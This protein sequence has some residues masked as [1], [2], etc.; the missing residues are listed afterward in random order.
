MRR[1][2]IA[3]ALCIAAPVASSVQGGAQVPSATA[4]GQQP[5]AA[6]LAGA[7]GPR[8]VLDKYCVTCHNQRLKTAGLMLDTLDPARIG[9]RAE[10]WEKVVRKI[11][12]GAMPPA[13]RPRPD[14]ALADGVA[15][16]IEESLDRVAAEH[17]DPGRPTLH[18]LN[19][20][21]YANA[22]RDL[23]ALE[24]D[25]ASLL[26]ADNA[27]YGFDNNADALSLSPALAERY[28]GAAAKIS[29]MAVG[30]VRGSSAAE[31]IF[32]PSDRNQGT[33][34]SEDLPWGSRGGL[35]IRYEFPVEGEYLFQLRLNESG[36][37]GGIMGITAETQTLDVSLDRARIWTTTVG[38]PAAVKEGG[39]E[40]TKK[41][42]DALQFRASVTAGSHLVQAYFTQRT[43]AFLE[44]LFD[45]YL[46]RDPY[47]AGN[48]EPG[49]SSISI[50][51]PAAARKNDS[52]SRRRLFVC[53]PKSAAA[54]DA[55]ARK[56]V[57]RLARRA[58]RRPVTGDDL[59]IPLDRYRD[60]ASGGID[61]GIELAVRSILV[62]PNF[63][64]RFERQPE[65]A[66]PNT[67]YRISDVEL[68]SRLSFFLWSSIPDDELVRVAESDTLHTP[69]M[70]EAQVKRMLADPR[71]AALVADFAGQW[72]HIRNVAGFQ[73]SPE[74]LFHFDDNLRH[75]FARETE[76]FFD[77]IIRENRSV[78]DLLDADYTFLNERLA[79]HYGIPGVHGERFRRVSLPSDSVR[80]GLIGQGSILT[81][82]SRPNRTSPVIRGKWILENIFGAPPPPPLPNVPQLKEE[83]DP[84]KILSM[85]EQM[86]QHRANPVC[87]SCH[88][89]MDELGFALENF[90]A[91]GEW[92][93]AD[94]AGRPI[95]AAAKLPDGTT[96]TGPVGLRKVLLK[97]SDDFLTTLTEKLL[98]YA[99][100]R[101]LEAADAPAVRLIKREAAPTAYRFASLVQG[102]VTSTPFQM[103]MAHAPN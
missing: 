42:L 30:R 20:I 7:G 74:L 96:F 76:L 32:V 31:T 21:E 13:G 66:A 68:A 71:S 97:H 89:Q 5:A 103:R 69:V 55:C 80:R 64:F 46:R 75:A 10:V 39:E 63:L 9:E 8:A 33:R 99:L 26:P 35:A 44:D 54:E 95:D 78:L 28:L 58:Y 12:T 11:R 70:L 2:L 87:A 82:T 50:T 102:I 88:A 53:E 14:K 86:A 91:I 18:R 56:I 98:T 24:I 92:R 51:A 15:A 101:G 27:A 6:T 84:A 90:D 34:F 81:D 41:I 62:S 59:R 79:K 17:P 47:R 57:E 83:R 94:A 52:P 1:A 22:I 36:A 60:G 16:S 25:P 49:I 29:E 43:S 67:P 4:V 73:P 100:G 38:G 65:N 40:R 48:G 23:L 72:L 19:R 37:D 93:D 45:P 3:A 77:S 61:S 85:R